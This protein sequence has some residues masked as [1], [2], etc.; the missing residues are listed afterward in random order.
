VEV[1]EKWEG[2]GCH[3]VKVD[4]CET[5]SEEA[6]DQADQGRKKE[7]RAQ[8]DAVS[9]FRAKN[10]SYAEVSQEVWSWEENAIRSRCLSCPWQARL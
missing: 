6:D 3:P 7:E 5:V 4:L 10:F 2:H 9:Y 1:E 8:S